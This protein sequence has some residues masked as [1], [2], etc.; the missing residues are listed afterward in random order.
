[1][2]KPSNLSKIAQE[3]PE[4][5]FKN[6]QR[7]WQR[8]VAQ[9]NACLRKRKHFLDILLTA[10]SQHNGLMDCDQVSGRCSRTGIKFNSIRDEK[11][12][13]LSFPKGIKIAY[14]TEASFNP[15]V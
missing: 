10:F 12:S 13:G 9:L 15:S 2:V 14:S 1:M 7:Q 3:Y 4:E 8:Y 5:A 11:D 6:F